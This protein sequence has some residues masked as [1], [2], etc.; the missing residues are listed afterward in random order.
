MWLRWDFAGLLFHRNEFTINNHN[1]IRPS[2]QPGHAVDEEVC[3]GVIIGV[4][5]FVIG[6]KST[7]FRSSSKAFSDNRTFCSCQEAA[8]VQPMAVMKRMNVAWERSFAPARAM[9]CKPKTMAPKKRETSVRPASNQP[10][11]KFGCSN[12][13]W[14]SSCSLMIRDLFGHGFIPSQPLSPWQVGRN[15]SSDQQHQGPQCEVSGEDQGGP[16]AHRRCS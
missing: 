14:I 11:M 4:G 1:L 9:A 8:K 10:P 7:S 3:R 12:T 15:Q 5:H 16:Y 13:G 6:S 2:T